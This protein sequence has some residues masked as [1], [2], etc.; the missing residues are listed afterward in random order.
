MSR[1]IAVVTTHNNHDT[2]DSFVERF[3]RACNYPLLVVDRHSTD[4]TGHQAE[5][6]SR[7]YGNIS[8]LHSPE[9]LGFRQACTQGFDW[10]L[11]RDFDIVCQLR[12]D[13]SHPP[14]LAPDLVG[15]IEQ[16]ADFV[17]ATRHAHGGSVLGRAAWRRALSRGSS[18]YSKKML[19]VDVSD[20]TSGYK[21]YHRRVL[22]TVDLGRLYSKADA[23]FQIEMTFRALLEGFALAEVPYTS[24]YVSSEE[25]VSPRII[26]EAALTMW[27]LRRDALLGRL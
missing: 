16:G 23:P 20:L 15:C 8:L 11:E 1:C 18:L 6:L 25:D 9:E 19:S 7:T 26:S 10:A 12:A 5:E 27:R 24:E 3:R 2:L 21:A 4:G 22:E 14:G 17:I 13:L